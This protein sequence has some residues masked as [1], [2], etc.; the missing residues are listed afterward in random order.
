MA[1]CLSSDG[2][3]SVDL[4]SET[5]ATY[6]PPFFRTVVC[7]VLAGRPPSIVG[8]KYNDASGP[9]PFRTAFVLQARAALHEPH[10]LMMVH[11]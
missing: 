3:V 10:Q 1:T 9:F 11:Q 6:F 5:R 4:A 2:Y 8:A 7:P